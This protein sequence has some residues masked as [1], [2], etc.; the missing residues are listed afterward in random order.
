MDYI[1]YWTYLAYAAGYIV[2]SIF[3]YWIMTRD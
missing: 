1:L 3:T 2:G